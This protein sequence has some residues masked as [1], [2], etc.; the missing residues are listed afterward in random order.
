MSNSTEAG[1][2]PGPWTCLELSGPKHHEPI[3]PANTER[4]PLAEA[5]YWKDCPDYNTRANA[6]LIAAAPDLLEACEALPL[7]VEFEDAADFKDNARA[8]MEAMSLARAAIKK[9]MG[10]NP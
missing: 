5:L 2:T 9:A 1:H 8:F 7:E 6:R 10:V 4:R 3:Y